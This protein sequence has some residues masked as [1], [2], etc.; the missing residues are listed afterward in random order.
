[1]LLM[2]KQAKQS[3]CPMA[4]QG[5]LCAADGCAMWRWHEPFPQRRVAAAKGGPNVRP[6]NVPDDWVFHPYDPCD[7][8]PA[9]WAEP[10][11]SAKAR[12]HGYCGLA[13]RPE[14]A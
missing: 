9:C 12:R 11:E 8:D 7:R 10:V 13:G 3:L 2:I 1:M 4:G 6:P 5:G 14:V